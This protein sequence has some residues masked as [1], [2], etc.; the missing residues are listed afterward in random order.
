[1]TAQKIAFV[2]PSSQ[3]NFSNCFQVLPALVAACF[4]YLLLCKHCAVTK[5]SVSR[6]QEP[7]SIPFS[8]FTQLL[9]QTFSKY[10]HAPTS[11]C[12][13][14]CLNQLKIPIDRATTTAYYWYCLTSRIIEWFGLEGTLKLIWFQTPCHE[15]GHPPLDQ[16]AQTCKILFPT[17]YYLITFNIWVA[18]FQASVCFSW[19]CL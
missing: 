7:I 11:N 5:L 16:V 12:F 3:R 9:D 2:V 1:M 19:N 10:T 17:N 8:I 4:P 18:I 15:Q 6:C 14:E 13:S